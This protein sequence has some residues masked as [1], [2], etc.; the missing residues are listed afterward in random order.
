MHIL[1]FSCFNVLHRRERNAFSHMLCSVLP[2]LQPHTVVR[3]ILVTGD[4]LIFFLFADAQLFEGGFM[5]S[6]GGL[7][8]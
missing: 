4:I 8:G 7:S 6:W 2:S 5:F 1:Y 3:G